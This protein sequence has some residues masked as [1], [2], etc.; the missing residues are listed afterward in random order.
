MDVVNVSKNITANALL[1]KA[2]RQKLKGEIAGLATSRMIEEIKP[3]MQKVI[4]DAL[5]ELLPE[6][7]S[8]L[9]K[10]INELL[11]DMSPNM[12]IRSETSDYGDA[13]NT[14]I[15]VTYSLGSKKND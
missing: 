1:A 3:K 6:A 11:I 12:G 5:K 14:L 2:Y 7:Q 10:H 13:I 9:E 15:D 4:T 8:I